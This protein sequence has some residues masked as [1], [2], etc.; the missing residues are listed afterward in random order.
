MRKWNYNPKKDVPKSHKA[1]K[2]FFFHKINLYNSRRKRNEFTCFAFF[3]CCAPTQ[4][5]LSPRTVGLII[6]RMSIWLVRLGG[7][8]FK[9]TAT[10]VINWAKIMYIRIQTV[11]SKTEKHSH[12]RSTKYNLF[13]KW[14][15]WGVYLKVDNTPL[16]LRC[17][18]VWMFVEV[19]AIRQI[20][21]ISWLKVHCWFPVTYIKRQMFRGN[22]RYYIITPTYTQV[23]FLVTY[24]YT[25]FRS[26]NP[27]SVTSSDRQTGMLWDPTSAVFARIW[28]K[29]LIC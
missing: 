6:T 24:T 4:L 18:Y 14:S 23:G 3:Q 2:L 10:L 13:V 7:I 16:F 12:P 27:L 29:N 20:Y 11:F 26:C 25:V 15:T 17:L 9:I 1:L 8:V 19:K 5:L 21:S 28:I 22:A